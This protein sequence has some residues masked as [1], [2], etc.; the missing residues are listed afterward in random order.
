MHAM[1]KLLRV[2]MEISSGKWHVI[3][4]NIHILLYFKRS[5]Q[6]KMYNSLTIGELFILNLFLR[7]RLWWMVTYFFHVLFFTA[8][9]VKAL[10]SL[11]ILHHNAHYIFWS[12]GINGLMLVCFGYTILINPALGAWVI[13]HFS[14][15]DSIKRVRYIRSL[16]DFLVS[17]GSLF[18]EF[19]CC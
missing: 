17:N 13:L 5:S 1:T 9:G 16:Y 4:L 14:V 18:L 15:S 10:K 7:P 2:P 11:S 8:A 12:F 19:I 3:L 6:F